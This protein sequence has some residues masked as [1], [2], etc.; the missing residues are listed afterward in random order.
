MTDITKQ[1][2]NC[3]EDINE[4]KV[5]ILSSVL[6]NLTLSEVATAICRMEVGRIKILKSTINDIYSHMKKCVA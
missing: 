5:N 4:N 3:A 2:H 6:D 1:E